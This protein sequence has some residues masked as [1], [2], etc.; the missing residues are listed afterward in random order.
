M[1]NVENENLFQNTHPPTQT[2]KENGSQ[3]EIGSFS[4]DR[5]L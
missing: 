2:Q 1:D 3:L 4:E 5:L